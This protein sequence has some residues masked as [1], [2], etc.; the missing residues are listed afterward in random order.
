MSLISVK[1]GFN[2][3]KRTQNQ[4]INVGDFHMKPFENEKLCSHTRSLSSHKNTFPSLSYLAA[5]IK[6]A[7]E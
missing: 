2:C 1:A 7:S 3:N 4:D 6:G 5:D